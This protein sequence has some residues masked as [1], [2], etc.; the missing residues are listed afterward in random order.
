VGVACAPRVGLRSHIAGAA[1]EGARTWI[2]IKSDLPLAAAVGA[3]TGL[4][5]VVLDR[6]SQP[7][8][9]QA[10]QVLQNQPRGMSITLAGVLYG[11]ITEELLLRW[12]LM[13]VLAW[14]GWRIFQRG[15]DVPRA[16]LM[17]T[18][19]VVSA[20]LFGVG[21]LGA[22]VALVPL[23]FAVV[24]RT[25]LLNALAGMVF[26]YVFWR[27]SLEAAMVA[28]AGAHIAMTLV[29][30]VLASVRA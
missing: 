29:S 11:G 5:I 16:W 28:H 17:W 8:M 14:A 23:T 7:W 26:G 10:L 13:S 20:L 24:V 1:T 6:L 27:R 12:G 19:I 30:V 4:S 21:H 15:E 22:A 9:P 18:A 3:A 25:V 2:K